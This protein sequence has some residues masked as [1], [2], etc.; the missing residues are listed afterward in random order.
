MIT[1][2]NDYFLLLLLINDTIHFTTYN[3]HFTNINDYYY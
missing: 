2:I 3:A 1:N